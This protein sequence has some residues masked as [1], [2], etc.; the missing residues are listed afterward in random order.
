ME[1]GILWDTVP[2]EL[3]SREL[4]FRENGCSEMLIYGYL[5][6]MISVQCVQ[7]NLDR[8]NHKN[9]VLTLKDRYQKEFSVVCNCEF[10]YNTI[11]NSLPYSL[12]G[13]REKLEKLGIRAYRLSFTLEN[14]K[15]TGRIAREFVE[16]YGKRQEPKEEDLLTGTTR[17]HFGRGVE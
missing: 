2:L 5:P 16:V 4:A 15:E 10:C 3:N 8:C 7:K 11:Y 1:E 12:L 9:A 13:E 14:E 17:G 6:L